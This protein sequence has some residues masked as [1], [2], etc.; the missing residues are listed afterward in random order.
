MPNEV[1]QLKHKHQ[2]PLVMSDLSI[3]TRD[4]IGDRTTPNAF[5]LSLSLD[6]ADDA[7]PCRRRPCDLATVGVY[8]AVDLSAQH[9]QLAFGIA[10]AFANNREDDAEQ[11][12]NNSPG[13]RLCTLPTADEC[14]RARHR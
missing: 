9:I 12:T 3:N 11:K 14:L 4:D 7:F 13:L 5:S 2:K 8:D 1:R 10:S 6:I